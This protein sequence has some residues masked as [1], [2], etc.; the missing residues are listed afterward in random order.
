[1]T[2]AAPAPLLFWNVAGKRSEKESDGDGDV[3]GTCMEAM[4]VH[5]APW[6]VAAVTDW[7]VVVQ[8][9]LRSSDDFQGHASFVG[10]RFC[11]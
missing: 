1:M 7:L 3:H 6:I 8:R 11:L 10:P 4:H 2:T 9:N 5:G